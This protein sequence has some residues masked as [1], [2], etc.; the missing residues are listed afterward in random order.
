MKKWITMLIAVMA[1]SVANAVEIQ[2]TGNGNWTNAATWSPAQV[3]ALADRVLIK[4][5]DTV[6]VDSAGNEVG[7]LRLDAGK[8]YLNLDAGG[9]LTVINSGNFPTNGVVSYKQAATPAAITVQ[10]GSFVVQGDFKMDGGNSGV[11]NQLNVSSG[12]IDLVFFE[13]GV[14]TGGGLAMVD[15]FGSD[16]SFTV[17]GNMKLGSSSILRVTPAADGSVTPI[18][19]DN[20]KNVILEG[21]ALAVDMTAMKGRLAEIMLI[22][23]NGSDA[24]DGTFGATNLIGNSDYELSY[25]GGDGNDIVLIRTASVLPSS[26]L[27]AGWTRAQE[28]PSE[29][30]PAENA[31]KVRVDQID[32]SGSSDK[33]DRGSSDLTY[34]T[35]LFTNVADEASFHGSTSCYALAVE[36]AL[37]VVMTNSYGVNG[38]VFQLDYVLADWTAPFS[39]SPKTLNIKYVEGDLGIP[40]GTLLATDW[41]YTSGLT[42]ADDYADV[43]AVLTGY[44]SADRTLTNGQY[45]VFE[46]TVATNLFGSDGACYI[47]NIALAATITTNQTL[48]GYEAWAADYPALTGGE[49]DDDDGDG[50]T[51]L[52]EFGLGGSPVDSGSIGYVPE[53][54]PAG[55]FMEFVHVRR[56]TADNGLTYVLEQAV[57][58][59]GGVWTNTGDIVITGTNSMPSDPDFEAITNQISIAG[60]TQEFIRLVIE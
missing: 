60:K 44:D 5:D 8:A 37:R 27:I 36:D 3:P 17:N 52:E 31:L 50:L 32:N 29:K 47:D 34:G 39:Q 14:S 23:N 46:I 11:T 4:F 42:G 57:D 30:N 25:T 45:A 22:D 51:N 56:T 38:L 2:S 15:I 21:G 59:V 35:G 7:G 12:L 10:G 58:L 18:I 16:A 33:F 28:W 53:F 48:S 41:M 24:I 55:E 6:T 20:F 9:E 1:G 54:G 26:Q 43:D 13:A 40:V 49:Q 19:S